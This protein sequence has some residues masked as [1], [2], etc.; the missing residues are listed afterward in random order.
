MTIDFNMNE[1]K[2]RTGF[3]FILFTGIVLR[4]WQIGWGLPEIFEEAFPFHIA[5]KFWNWNGSGYDFNPH[6][7]NYPALTF[8][9][10]FA[11]QAAQFGIGHLLGIY[12]TLVS[13][14]N[15]V[16]SSIVVIRLLSIAFDAG[17]I[18]TAYKLTRTMFG[19]ATAL[20]TAGLIAVNT[21]HI[22][23]AHLHKCRYCIDI[24][25]DDLHVVYLENV[26]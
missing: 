23:Q 9:L 16:S 22:K 10:T 8:Y 13:F 4:L 5:A 11:V 25:R 24:L 20:L 12:P 18:V 1:K 7:F 17:T 6:F 14:G 3:L 21:L 26:P 19:S 2:E 15:D